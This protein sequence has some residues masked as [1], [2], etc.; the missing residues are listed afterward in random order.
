MVI[1]VL[2]D[3]WI[4]GVIK[5]FV[6]AFVINMWDDVAIDTLSGAVDAIIDVVPDIIGVEVLVDVNVNNFGYSR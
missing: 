1:V 2:A 4:E 3:V 6:E 5:I